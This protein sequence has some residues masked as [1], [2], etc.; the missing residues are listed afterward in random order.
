MRVCARGTIAIKFRLYS[1]AAHDVIGR[2]ADEK[3]HDDDDGHF[4]GADFR[5]AEVAEA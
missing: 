5:L 1:P 2:P 3:H 4:Q